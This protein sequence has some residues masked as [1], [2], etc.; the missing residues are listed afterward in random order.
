MLN[1]YRMFQV[2]I[3]EHRRCEAFCGQSTEKSVKF[4]FKYS[5][6]CEIQNNQFFSSKI[7]KWRNIECVDA[8]WTI[9]EFQLR[10]LII[11]SCGL[12]ELK[13]RS[14]LSEKKAERTKKGTEKPLNVINAM[15]YYVSVLYTVHTSRY[16]CAIDNSNEYALRHRQNH[17]ESHVDP[18]SFIKFLYR[19][20]VC[21]C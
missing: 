11:L 12:N 13:W 1:S 6:S 7:N 3:C 10:M 9:A 14:M 21:V 16:G 8:K 20:C 4:L 17:F 2:H 5:P 18:S 19:L 15:R